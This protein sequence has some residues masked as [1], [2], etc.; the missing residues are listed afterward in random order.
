MV[1]VEIQF[2]LINITGN[3]ADI[4][5]N[6]TT[7]RSLK[8]HSI[9]RENVPRVLNYWNINNKCSYDIFTSYVYVII[10]RDWHWLRRS[11]NWKQYSG[12]EAYVIIAFNRVN[13]V[14]TTPTDHLFHPCQI[15]KFKITKIILK[16]CVCCIELC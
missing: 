11:Q 4:R 12:F 8:E 5:V 16:F 9:D 1:Q 15:N 14:T 7:R 10:I 2:K 6:G 13:N 3:C